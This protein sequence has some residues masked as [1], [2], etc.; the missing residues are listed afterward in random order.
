MST[1]IKRAAELKYALDAILQP[2]LQMLRKFEELE[3]QLELPQDCANIVPLWYKHNDHTGRPICL[4]SLI[5][6]CAV[7]ADRVRS[8][9]AGTLHGAFKFA[10]LQEC[11]R[12]EGT[13]SHWTFARFLRQS[14]IRTS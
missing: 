7:G 10:I 2:L 1:V 11:A 6:P 14:L 5:P 9:G 4:T 3:C 13:V 8:M 12:L